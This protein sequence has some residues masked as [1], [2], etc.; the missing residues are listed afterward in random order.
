M[1]STASRH[2][3]A[4]NSSRS[5]VRVPSVVLVAALAVRAWREEAGWRGGRAGG[6]C[7]QAAV[8]EIAAGSAFGLTAAMKRL[9]A[10]QPGLTLPGPVVSVTWGVPAFGRRVRGGRFTLAD[11]ICLAVPAG[12]VLPLAC[13]P[14]PV[15][16]SP[17]PR[18]RGRAARPGG[19]P[20][21]G[22]R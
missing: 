11:V 8:P 13:S 3:C 19:A 15:D 5:A 17:S 22:R 18:G 6:G 20:A 4:G 21:Q 2:D 12:A 1:A 7:R 16:H 14:L 9:I 10:V